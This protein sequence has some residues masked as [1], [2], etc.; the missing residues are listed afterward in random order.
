[1]EEVEII[2]VQFKSILNDV[3]GNI[4]A[5]RRIIVSAMKEY[6]QTKLIVFPELA[7]S[8]YDY[9]KDL[10]KTIEILNCESYMDSLC[11]IVKEQ[12]V[13]IIIGYPEK[14]EGKVFNSIV[15]IDEYGKIKGNYRKMHLVK[16]EKTIFKCGDRYTLINTSFGKLG[17][18]ICWDLAFPEEARLYAEN[19]ADFLIASAAW[20]YPYENQYELA[21][22]ARAL[23]NGIPVIASNMIGKNKE[24]EFCGNSL[25][26]DGMGN[27]IEA[28]KTKENGYIHHK[29]IKEDTLNVRKEFASQLEELRCETYNNEYLKRGEFNDSK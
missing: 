9:S 8:G 5:V 13:S 16:K 20:E 7:L 11:N 23:D 6:P 4:E 24:M 27:I 19:K 21:V 29:F 15:F 22:R 25:F 26:A 12:K 18:L 3:K 1:M 10:L 2:A 14:I 17:L 28:C